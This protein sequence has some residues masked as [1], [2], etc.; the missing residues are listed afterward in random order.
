MCMFRYSLP[1]HSYIVAP[2]YI[3]RR[4]IAHMATYETDSSPLA[5]PHRQQTRLR[6]SIRTLERTGSWTSSYNTLVSADDGTLEGALQAA[7]QEMVEQE[8]FG[9]LIREAGNLPTASARVAERL[10]V[11]DAAQGMELRF[12][13][14][15]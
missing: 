9:V 6:V 1:S 2:P 12:E 11:V 10:I 8:I 15:R 5:F 3:R 4:A 13:L 14:V 7:Q